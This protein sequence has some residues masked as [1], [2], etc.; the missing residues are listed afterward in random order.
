[1]LI[2]KCHVVYLHF[3]AA[4]SPTWWSA[5]KHG[6][7]MP[8]T[9]EVEWQMECVLYVLI[10]AVRWSDGCSTDH[11]TVICTEVRADGGCWLKTDCV[12]EAVH[13]ANPPS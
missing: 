13:R 3:A 6:E 4:Q 7:V 8:L 2:L 5:C 10:A 11:L 12:G 9:D 1:M